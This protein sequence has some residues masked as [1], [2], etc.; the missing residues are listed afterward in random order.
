MEH[1]QIEIF[2]S[3]NLSSHRS[4]VMTGTLVDR[5]DTLLWLEQHT[6]IPAMLV[7]MRESLRIG[8]G[9]DYADAPLNAM[10]ERL[11]EADDA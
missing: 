1:P 7:S 6:V 3:P 11:A 4:W 10:R 8:V 5:L 9:L 2:E